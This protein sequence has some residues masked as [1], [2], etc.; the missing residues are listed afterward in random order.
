MAV[1][2]L[3]KRLL[4]QILDIFALLDSGAD[5]LD[6]NLDFLAIDVLGLDIDS[7]G[8]FGCNV[9]VAAGLAGCCASLANLTCSAH[10][11]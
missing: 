11:K 10:M 2:I 3:S 7:L 9:R 6:A 5:A 1:F 8:S 4:Q